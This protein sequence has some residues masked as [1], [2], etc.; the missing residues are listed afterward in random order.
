MVEKA[1]KIT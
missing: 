1:Q